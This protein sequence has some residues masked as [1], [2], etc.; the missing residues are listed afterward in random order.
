MLSDWTINKGCLKTHKDTKGIDALIWRRPTEIQI[1]KQ[2]KESQKRIKDL[3]KE[4][5]N[6]ETPQQFQKN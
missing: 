3:K 1:N 6:L 5:K 2:H 4:K